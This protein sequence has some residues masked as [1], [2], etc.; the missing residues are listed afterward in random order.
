MVSKVKICDGWE[1]GPTRPCDVTQREG[2]RV[3]QRLVESGRKFGA[4]FVFLK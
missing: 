4:Y 2:Q 1:P 3:L